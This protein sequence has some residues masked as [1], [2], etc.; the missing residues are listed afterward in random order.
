MM[1]WVRKYVWNIYHALY[2]QARIRAIVPPTVNAIRKVNQSQIT[3]LLR[4]IPQLLYQV[5]YRPRH[6]CFNIL[7]SV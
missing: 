5:L 1:F 6:Y 7:D 4:R 3:I 2:L